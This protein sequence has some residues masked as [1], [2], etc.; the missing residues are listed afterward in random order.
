[1][2]LFKNLSDD[3]LC[4]AFSNIKSGD[5][6][7]VAKKDTNY[8][9]WTS[10]MTNMIGRIYNVQKRDDY[11]FYLI[12]DFGDRFVFSFK[13][14]SFTTCTVKKNCIYTVGDYTYKLLYSM[15]IDHLKHILLKQD[16]QAMKSIFGNNKVNIYN[17]KFKKIK[18]HCPRVI[19]ALLSQEVLIRER[20]KSLVDDTF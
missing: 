18:E 2:L 10:Q 15:P 6:V 12:D 20:K 19:G 17:G 16:Y 8:Y 3:Q 1:M 4:K 7:L 5:P 13:S 11:G 14:L 9:S